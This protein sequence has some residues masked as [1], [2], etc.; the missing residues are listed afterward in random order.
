MMLY[1]ITYINI[2]NTYLTNNI[3]KY[4][5]YKNNINMLNYLSDYIYKDANIISVS[6]LYK[7]ILI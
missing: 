6:L 3:S 4:R 5:F 7:N 2:N 1:I